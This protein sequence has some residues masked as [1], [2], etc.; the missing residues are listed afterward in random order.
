MQR[1]PRRIASSIAAL[2]AALFLCLAGTAHAT[3]GSCTDPP[4][5]V[6]DQNGNPAGTGPLDIIKVSHADTST[7]VTYGLQT[8]TGFDTSDVDFIVWGIDTNGDSRFEGYL[9]VY[10]DPLQAQLVDNNDNV[11]ENGTVTHT[12]GAATLTV[13]L[14]SAGLRDIAVVKTYRYFVIAQQSYYREDGAGP[15]THTLT[16]ALSAGAIKLSSTT[17]TVGGTLSGT[18]SGFKPGSDVTVTAHSTTTT[19]G[20]VPVD[21]NGNAAFSFKLPSTIGVGTHTVVVSGVDP[22]GTAHSESATFTVVA[23]AST[24]AP[25]L[26]KTGGPIAKDFAVGLTVLLLGLSWLTLAYFGRRDTPDEIVASDVFFE[27]EDAPPAR[28]LGEMTGPIPV[29]RPPIYGLIPGLPRETD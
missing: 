23:A 4:N 9:V 2:T 12:D 28:D 14:A 27:F 26:Q 17:V 16:T 20:T 24:S 10:S 13:Q 7:T 29:I 18:A 15:C 6:Q 3:S 22:A 21:I 11:V 1:G 25:T 5:D 19:L 8:L